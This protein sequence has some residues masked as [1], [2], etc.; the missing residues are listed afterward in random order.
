MEIEQ[1]DEGN[2]QR[3]EYSRVEAYVPFEC[4][5]IDKE[6][7]DHIKTKILGMNDGND[8][9][10]LPDMGE[11]DHILGEW[12]KIINTKIDTVIRLIT[13]QREGYFCL[14]YKAINISGGGMS[15]PSQQEMVLGDILEIK[16]MLTQQQP[17]ALSVYGEVVKARKIDGGFFIAVR[18]VHMDEFVRDEIIRFVFER[19]RE[20]IREKRG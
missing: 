17:L 2:N 9:R 6:E 8:L 18:Y 14:S 1:M 4:R 3:R 5:V 20:I 7:L 10:P 19:E 12:L 15:F 11:S 13:L 16:I